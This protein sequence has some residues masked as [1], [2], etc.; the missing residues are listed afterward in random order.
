MS[1][2]Q[3]EKIVED[4]LQASFDSVTDSTIVYRRYW[5]VDSGTDPEKYTQINIRAGT[6]MPLGMRV[7]E[8]DLDV[9]VEIVSY[10]ADDPAHTAA[11]A[12]YHLI[13]AQVDT[14]AF[15]HASLKSF[16]VSVAEGTLPFETEHRN[17]IVLALT[18]KVCVDTS[19]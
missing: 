12:A 8:R 4:V 19:S 7:C 16:D 13:R 5:T 2:K 14:S 10:A 3:V 6:N 11:A 18:A 15:A 17:H 9:A 1:Y